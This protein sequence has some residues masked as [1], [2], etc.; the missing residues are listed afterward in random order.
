MFLMITKKLTPLWHEALL[1]LSLTDKQSAIL[2]G[3]GTNRYLAISR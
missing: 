3:H 2:F 1:S